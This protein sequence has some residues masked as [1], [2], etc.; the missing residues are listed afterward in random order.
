MD[1]REYW[2]A[3]LT[4][5]LIYGIVGLGL[6]LLAGFTGQ[7]SIG[8][9]AFLGVGA[10]TQAY[11]TGSA[12]RS[13]CRWSAVRAAVGRRRAWSW[14]CP[15]ARQ[16][17]LPRHRDA[18]AFGFIVEEVFARWESVTGGN[19]GVHVK[20][21]N[22]LF[23][24]TLSSDTEFYFLCLVQCACWSRSAVLNL[25]RSPDRP[26][27][28]RDPRL[29]DF[30]AEHGHQPGQLQG[31]SLRCRRPWQASAG[32]LYAH[33]MQFLSPDQFNIIQSI[34]LLLLVVIGGL[35]SCTAPSWARSS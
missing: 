10:Y 8:H 19:A 20:A 12:G 17:H 7:L 35:G 32:A 11:L 28:R 25:L 33:K 16:G 2:L 15:P 34:D 18:V 3:Q 24:W 13:R 30:G 5:V 27:V 1:H 9:A 6:M 29:R 4:F 23:G 31:V 22:M 21:P 26:R 14:A